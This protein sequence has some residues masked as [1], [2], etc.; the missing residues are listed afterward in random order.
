M[1]SAMLWGAVKLF[2]GIIVAHFIFE[3][4]KGIVN[5]RNSKRRDQWRL[6]KD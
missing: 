1:I 2:F 6:P 3:V 4:I 5:L